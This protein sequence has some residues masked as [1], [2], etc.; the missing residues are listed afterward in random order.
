LQTETKQKPTET[1]QI[2]KLFVPLQRVIVK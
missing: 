1:N 2:Q